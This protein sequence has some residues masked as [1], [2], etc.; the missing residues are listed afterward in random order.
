VSDSNK[1]SR[2]RAKGTCPD[3]KSNNLYL[4]EYRGS[5]AIAAAFLPR[6]AFQCADCN[7]RFWGYQS[8]FANALRVWMLL[9]C[10]IV[11]LV[12]AFLFFQPHGDSQ[13]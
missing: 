12:V 7:T 11:I 8:L 4:S 2:I 10:F 1:K 3:C 5:E 9:F 13:K 6:N